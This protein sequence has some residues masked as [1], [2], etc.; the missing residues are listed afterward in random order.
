MEKELILKIMERALEIN[1]RERNT[2][3][4]NYYGHVDSISIQIH[5]NGWE[6]DK[7]PDYSKDIYIEGRLYKQNKD[8]LQEVLNKLDKIKELSITDQSHDSSND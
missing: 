5:T 6:K 4:I 8:E 3:F 1:S 7:D 2:I